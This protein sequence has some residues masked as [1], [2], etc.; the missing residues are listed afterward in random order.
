[1]CPN[2]GTR[3]VGSGVL[4]GMQGLIGFNGDRFAVLDHPLKVVENSVA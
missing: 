2:G 4:T 1:M 3:S